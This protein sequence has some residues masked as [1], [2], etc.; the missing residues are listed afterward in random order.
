MRC[1]DIPTVHPN[2]GAAKHASLYVLLCCLAYLI[3]AAP[4]PG[5]W[6]S[7]PE[8]APVE[9]PAGSRKTFPIPH[10][11]LGCGSGTRLLLQRSCQHRRPRGSPQATGWAHLQA[12][13]VWARM[14][15][16]LI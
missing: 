2:S 5:P 10:F 12:Q 11:F 16:R 14:Q 4:C 9:L 7:E 8:L 6:S 3:G 15:A 1:R 13:R